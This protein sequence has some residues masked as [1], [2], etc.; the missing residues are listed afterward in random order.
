MKD[1]SN[2]ISTARL[3]ISAVKNTNVFN[4]FTYKIKF[5]YKSVCPIQLP[6]N[7]QQ[8]AAEHSNCSKIKLQLTESI[9]AQFAIQAATRVPGQLFSIVLNLSLI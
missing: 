9:A 3:L 2:S 1:R 6:G 7:F 4:I 8:S 5:S